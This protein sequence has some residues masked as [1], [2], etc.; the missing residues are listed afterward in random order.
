VRPGNCGLKRTL[1]V[2]AKRGHN[3]HELNACRGFAG[4]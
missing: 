3:G 2:A 4:T 1:R